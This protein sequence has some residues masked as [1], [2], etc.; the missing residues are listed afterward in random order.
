MTFK[1][2][3]L[4][5]SAHV[6]LVLWALSSF[7][8]WYF[9][10]HAFK[11]YRV[12]LPTA[13]TVLST[14]FF[15]VIALIWFDNRP[16]FKPVRIAIIPFVQ[17]SPAADK[18]SWE[19]LAI[20]EM[21]ASLISQ[22][23]RERF[24]VY[25]VEWITACAN[26]D[27][28]TFPE[29]LLALSRRIKLDYAVWGTFTN[30]RS[31]YALEYHITDVRTDEE[32]WS[33][34]SSIDEY[35]LMDF[36]EI[37]SQA[38]LKRVL[39]V[40]YDLNNTIELCCPVQIENYF[41][42]RLA[43]QWGQIGRAFRFAENALAE[44]TS[45]VMSSNLLA[46]LI[47]QQALEKQNEGEDVF[48]E[49][50]KAK[51][52]L[53]KANS[54][55]PDDPVPLRLLGELYLANRKWRDAEKYFFE[56]HKLNP[57]EPRVYYAL[58]RLHPTRYSRLGFKSEV[59][60]LKRAVDINPG[61]FEAYLSLASYYSMKNRYDLAQEAVREILRINPNSV[62]GLMALA[63]VYLTQN[64][65]LKVLDTYERVLELEPDNGDVFYNLGIV[66]YY[67][68]DFDN[69][70]K[71]FKHAIKLNDHLDSRLYLAYIYE[72]EG[73]LTKAVDYLRTRIRKRKNEDD[74]FAEEARKHLFRIM[75][76][77]GII[78]SLMSKSSNS[79]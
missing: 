55:K 63:K 1:A 69:A 41:Q 10:R 62:D 79:H 13:L 6:V 44:D 70:I 47:L 3:N 67:Q 46:E 50:K 7:V 43:L 52:I 31:S 14:L 26:R 39:N 56:S 37:L 76:E 75:N 20:S 59:E 29:Y 12:R 8:V 9:Y 57:F 17:H 72:R 53:V 19:G 58:T 77:Q 74:Q 61:F 11:K 21:T 66:Y 40:D 42:A 49:Y 33:E 68:E 15:F 73:D 54:F 35:G 60:L 22:L 27:S 24:L 38:T 36:S 51:S 65:L 16:T 30:N 64:D 32:I 2:L 5:E 4:P 23:D 28:L 34:K 25:P 71:Y 78:D 18:I 48:A 45:S